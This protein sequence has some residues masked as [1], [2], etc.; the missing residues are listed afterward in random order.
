VTAAGRSGARLE[1]A[2]TDES[3]AA[4]TADCS[5]LRRHL[6]E[7]ALRTAL[8]EGAALWDHGTVLSAARVLSEVLAGAG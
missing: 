3:S 8:N 4:S 6:G 5:A 2:G 7:A 1:D